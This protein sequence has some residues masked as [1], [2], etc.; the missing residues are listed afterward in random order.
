MTNQ[1]MTHRLGERCRCSHVLFV[2]IVAFASTALWAAALTSNSNGINARTIAEPIASANR[3]LI[4]G[5]RANVTLANPGGTAINGGA[6]IY[7][8]RVTSPSRAMSF[9]D[10]GIG[11]GGLPG[12]VPVIERIA[13]NTPPRPN[14][15]YLVASTRYAAPS[16]GHLPTGNATESLA[17]T[18]A[19]S[20]ADCHRA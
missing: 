8:S 9:G 19:S 17:D 18:T 20:I 15:R 12:A 5:A 1:F 2:C 14:A 13:Q 7:A 3:D 10:L 6:L 16:A 11:A 4:A